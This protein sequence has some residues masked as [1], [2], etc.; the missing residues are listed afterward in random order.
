MPDSGYGFLIFGIVSLI[1]AVYATSTG[2]A[3]A[4]WGRVIQRAED[5][6]RFWRL[7]AA[8][9]L[10]SVVFIGAFIYRASISR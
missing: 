5:P 9:Y 6:K 2:E 4:R 1:Q 8:Y 10:G 3:W 7:V